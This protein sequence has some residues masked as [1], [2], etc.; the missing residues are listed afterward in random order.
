MTETTSQAVLNDPQGEIW[1]VLRPQAGFESVYQGEP[2]T[3][4]LQLFPATPQALPLEEEAD[5]RV[6]GYARQLSRYMNVP[7]GAT[8]RLIFPLIQARIIGQEPAIQRYYYQLRWRQRVLNDNNISG[9]IQRYSLPSRRGFDDPAAGPTGQPR[10]AIPAASGEVFYPDYPSNTNRN[11]PI[12][13]P[14]SS[15]TTFDKTLNQLRDQQGIYDPA[16]VD[17][18]TATTGKDAWG[19]TFYP[20]EQTPCLGDQ[21][22]VVMYRLT[23]NSTWDFTA[24]A[25]DDWPLAYTLGEGRRSVPFEFSFPANEAIGVFAS[26]MSRS[27]TP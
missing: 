18:T 6:I 11:S 13:L 19:P 22:T 14:S 21:L 5:R 25:G 8:L 16:I 9:A 1:T 24:E 7:N 17:P 12:Y 15:L 10:F 23:G 26:P 27:T 4:P 20:P 2:I 3:T